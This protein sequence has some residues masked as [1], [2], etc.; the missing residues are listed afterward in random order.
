MDDTVQPSAPRECDIEE[1]KERQGVNPI[2]L[3]ST[4]TFDQIYKGLSAP[5][6][7]KYLRPLQKGRGPMLT[8]IQAGYITQTLNMVV[9]IGGW[10]FTRSDIQVYEN[11]KCVEVSLH[12][13]DKNGQVATHTAF[14]GS[15]NP[16][17]DGLKSA[18]TD[19]L[20]KAA[21][22][23]GLGEE[24]FCGKISA[25]D[26]YAWQK[27]ETEKVVE[28]PKP[29]V[30]KK[31]TKKADPAAEKPISEKTVAILANLV[32]EHWEY[33]SAD[34]VLNF[35]AKVKFD[36][37]DWRSITDKKA[38]QLVDSLKDD[39]KLKIIKELIK[40]ERENTMT[41]VRKKVKKTQ[42]AMKGSSS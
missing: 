1:I 32:K 21:S 42:E 33:E 2:G 4:R 24:V 15:R 20:T 7:F 31:T 9:G 3:K 30:K 37:K 27:A 22:Y 26:I 11:N 41:D 19:G 12:I 34:I 18:V 28:E 10:A 13:A 29:A 5:V 25:E 17:P 23:F 8:T 36:T 38:L 35:M 14:G 6:P 39:K 40:K 16:G